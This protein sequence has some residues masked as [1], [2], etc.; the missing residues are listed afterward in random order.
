MKIRVRHNTLGPWYIVEEW[1]WWWPFW[2]YVMDSA[3]ESFAEAMETAER[4]VKN[5]TIWEV[6]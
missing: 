4:I 6:K 1:R 2:S 5:P 3:T